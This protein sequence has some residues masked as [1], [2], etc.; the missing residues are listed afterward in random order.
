MIEA[1]AVKRAG[2]LATQGIRGGANRES[3]NRIK[4]TGDIFFAVSDRDWVLDGAAVHISMVGF[5]DGTE[6]NRILDDKSVATINRNLTSNAD[7]TQAHR[8]DANLG[9]GFMGD[10]KGGSLRHRIRRCS[11]TA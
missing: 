10:T 9:V 4:Q 5:D 2:L 7:I 1:G 11:K 3:L 8:L 6:T